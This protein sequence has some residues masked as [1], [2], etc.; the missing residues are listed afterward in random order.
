MRECELIMNL[1]LLKMFHTIACAGNM[2]KASKILNTSQSSLSRAM[3]SLE[4]QL[5]IKLFK[6]NSRGISLTIDGKRVFEYASKLMQENE[7][8]L[9]SFYNNDTEIKGDLKIVTTAFLAEIELIGHLLPFLEEH[10]QLNIEIKTA[11]D[12]FD[13]EDADIAIRSFLPYRPDLEQLPLLTH[14]HKLWASSQYLERFSIPETSQ[15]LDHHRLLA[16]SLDKQKTIIYGDWL[17]WLLYI[18]STPDRPRKPFLQFTSQ[19]G[20]LNAACK[21]YG[22]LQFPQEWIHLTKAGLVEVLPQLEGPKIEICYIFNKKNRNSKK[23]DALYKYL[24]A[25][26]HKEARF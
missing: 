9:K 6:R 10:Q 26:I 20:L 12:S 15:D 23:I 2:T 19:S 13:T 11:S 18:G 16:F 4:Y 17:T 7:D 5:K 8:F 25:S 22:I 14:H 3:Q 1:E 24:Y 21:G